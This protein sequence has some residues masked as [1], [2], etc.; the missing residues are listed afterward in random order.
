MNATRYPGVDPTALAALQSDLLALLQELPDRQHG[1]LIAQSLETLIRIARTETDRLDWKIL[2][3]S[4]QDMQRA[5]ETFQPY[6]HTRKIA[7]FGSARTATSAPEYAMAQ[8]VARCISEQGFMVMTGAGGGIMAAANQGAGRS[9]SFGLNVH[10]PFEQ[11][12][13]PFIEGDGKLLRFKYFFTRKL[14]F[15]RETDGVIVFP[16]G[17]GTLDEAFEC[18]TLTQTGKFGPAPI[19]LVDRAGGDY[20]QDWDR[21]VRQQLIQKGL[22]SAEDPSLYTITDRLDVA[23]GA[24][25]HFYR[26]YHSSRYVKDQLVIRLK[27]ELSEAEVALLNENFADI[28]TQDQIRKSPALPAE[29][30]D[31]TVAMPRL[32]L[33]FNQR[34]VGRLYQMIEKINHM[35]SLHPEEI[36]P[37]HK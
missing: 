12:A 1:S 2:V 33:Y 13:N 27:T 34:D 22:I 7:I 28:L 26:V 24:I 29:L 17:F 36:H 6:R 37:E 3:G 30:G 23:C 35:G 31:E 20:W 9:A 25:N 18:L 8:S 5:F 15:L 11:T 10:L 14:F 16:G 4:L 19:V 21:Y 32:V